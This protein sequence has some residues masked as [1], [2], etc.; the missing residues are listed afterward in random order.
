[1]PLNAGGT[2]HIRGTVGLRLLVF[3]ACLDFGFSTLEIE[4]AV[5][6]EETLLFFS[7][8]TTIL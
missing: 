6:I 3:L 2:V 5:K 4:V 1:M 7:V 8:F